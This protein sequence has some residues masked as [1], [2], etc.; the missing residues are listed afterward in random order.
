MLELEETSAV[1]VNCY[2]LFTIY[3]QHL[4]GAP[5]NPKLEIYATIDY[6]HSEDGPESL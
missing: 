5:L 1:Q 3:V 4:K 2:I 6:A